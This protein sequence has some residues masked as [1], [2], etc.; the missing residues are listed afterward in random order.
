M[1][2]ATTDS[3]APDQGRVVPF[4]EQ[5]RRRSWR[6]NESWFSAVDVRAVLTGSVDAGAYW[7]KLRQHLVAESGPAV[8]FWH[9]LKPTAP[10][11]RRADADYPTETFRLL[12]ASE[13][14]EFGEYRTRRL[15]LGAWGQQVAAPFS[16]ESRPC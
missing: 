15:V 9:G 1:P 3:N 12:K 5:A 13:R 4:Q 8:T 6:Q 11:R 2:T 14:R 10:D 7:R 16:G